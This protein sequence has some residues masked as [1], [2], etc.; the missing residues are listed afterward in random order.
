MTG[1]S[2][3]RN[4]TFVEALS[5]E[6]EQPWVEKFCRKRGNEYLNEVTEEFLLDR[7]NLTHIGL[8]LPRFQQ[9]YDLITD[10]YS[11]DYRLFLMPTS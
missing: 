7:F 1:R 10:N 4:S 5:D 3:G 11:T 6:D 8:D 2:S 9:A